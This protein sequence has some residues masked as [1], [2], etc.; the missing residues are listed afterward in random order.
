MAR[1]AGEV[2]PAGVRR[3]RE[4]MRIAPAAS[5][6]SLFTEVAGFVVDRAGRVW[7]FDRPSSSLFLFGADGKLVRHVGREGGGPGEYKGIN[8]IVVLGDTGLA[9]WDG[10]NARVSFLDSAGAFRTS[11][12]V[13]G[14]FGTS[15][16]LVTDRSGGLYLKNPVTPP[17]EGEIIGRI[18]LVRPG[19]DGKIAD[20]LV[21]PDLKVP[22]EVYVA[23]HVY[24]KDSRSQSSMTSAYAPNYY[25][26]WHPGGFFVVADGGKY[27]IILA[28]R[29]AKPI[30]IR[31]TSAPVPVS[32]GERDEERAAI[33]FSMRRTDPAWSWSGPPL[34]ETKAPLIGQY[35]L[36]GLFVSRDGR[37]WTSVAAPSERIPDAELAPPRDPKAPVSHYRTPAV[38]EI[39]SADGRFLGRVELP[40]RARLMEADGDL[41]WALVR[42]ENDLPAVVRFRV[43]PGME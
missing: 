40:P 4:E 39:Y 32:A 26:A 23:V 7:V 2:S 27:E 1:V 28:R 36:R 43:E 11:W 3:L 17:R 21:P 30:V 29:S 16:G 31:R 34:P 13:P 42:D 25:W 37:I 38:Y 33:T 15:E 8:G 20:S 35:P 41:V 10:G 18:G 6:T 24:S 19:P 5:D 12:R 14:G 22:R 9:I